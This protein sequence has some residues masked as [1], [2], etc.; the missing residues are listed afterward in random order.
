[1][2]SWLIIL[3]S[4]LLLAGAARAELQV[5]QGTFSIQGIGGP[6]APA[7]T[8]IGV[9]T[10]NSS[11]GGAHVTTLDLPGGLFSIHTLVPVTGTSLPVTGVRIDLTLGSAH[12]AEASDGRLHGV[13]PAPGNVRICVLL[14]CGIFFDVPLTQGGTHGVGLGGAAI[15]APLGGLGTLSIVGDT[16]RT[17]N[18]AVQTS[19]GTI[20]A[21]GFAHG[22]LSNT[23]S[24]ASPDGVL[25]VVTPVALGIRVGGGDPG[26]VPLF[27]VLEVKF[28]P[29]P[30]SLTLCVAG[31][32]AL[33]GL[34]WRRA[35]R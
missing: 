35:R 27:G 7:A 6:S 29:E 33:I 24:T 21:A 31:A 2:R 9:A 4:G 26:V 13:L 34:G 16:W 25:Q 12:L 15:T 14:S 20:S 23:S 32:L 18:V 17:G 8:A 28:L 30:G 5:F 22:P 10:V 19:A 3:A 1:M 11:G